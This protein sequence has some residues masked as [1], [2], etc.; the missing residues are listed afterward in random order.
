MNESVREK[1]K[2]LDIDNDKQLISHKK[3]CNTSIARKSPMV[4]ERE[5]CQI[6]FSQACKSNLQERYVSLLSSVSDNPSDPPLKFPAKDT[7]TM[8]IR[9]DGS[10]RSAITRA[11]TRCSG[12]G[13]VQKKQR[14]RA[15][16]IN[17][18]AILPL[19]EATSSTLR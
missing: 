4:R 6:H 2:M 19:I 14:A 5:T 9:Q 10:P 16:G 7:R 3:T 13:S 11:R 12:N 18:A 17:R 1:E 8:R 15:R